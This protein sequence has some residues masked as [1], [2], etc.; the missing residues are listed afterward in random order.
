MKIKDTHIYPKTKKVI[1]TESIITKHQI[2][3]LMAYF[4]KDERTI[5]RWIMNNDERLQLPE[6]Q[7]ILKSGK[8]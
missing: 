2:R 4:N 3:K 1:I 7:Q 8:K 5:K 6:A